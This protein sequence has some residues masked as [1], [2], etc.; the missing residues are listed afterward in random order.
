MNVISIVFFRVVRQT[1]NIIKR[2]A[3]KARIENAVYCHNVGSESKPLSY[4][5]QYDLT[6][7]QTNT[8]VARVFPRSA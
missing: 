7:K 5:E 2:N 3:V 4:S 6:R 1:G 8:P